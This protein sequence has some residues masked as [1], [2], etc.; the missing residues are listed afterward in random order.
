MIS[1]E[2]GLP[3]SIPSPGISEVPLPAQEGDVPGSGA[4]KFPSWEVWVS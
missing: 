4:E 1:P 3:L 2:E